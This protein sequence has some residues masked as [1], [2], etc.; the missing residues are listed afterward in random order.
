MKK[1]SARVSNY[2]NKVFISTSSLSIFARNAQ[3]N[4]YIASVGEEKKPFQ[5]DLFDYIC[6]Q[7]KYLEQHVASVDEGKYISM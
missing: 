2:W 6:S 4:G 7:N 1:V 5:C 3:L